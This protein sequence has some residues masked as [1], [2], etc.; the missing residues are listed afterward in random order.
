LRTIVVIIGYNYEVLLCAIF[1]LA[2]I[3]ECRI[4]ICT[5]THDILLCVS[6]AV[7]QTIVLVGVRV[8]MSVCVHE[9]TEKLPI[10]N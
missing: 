2:P 5:I 1:Q 6:K 9:I 4:L 10:R 3:V 8:C 7:E